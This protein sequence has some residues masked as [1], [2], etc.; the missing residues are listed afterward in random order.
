MTRT[1]RRAGSP[2]SPA[3]IRTSSR[4][5]ANASRISSDACERILPPTPRSK[6]PSSTS[7]AAASPRR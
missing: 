7:S 6:R 3:S 1:A 5:P 4:L 2:W